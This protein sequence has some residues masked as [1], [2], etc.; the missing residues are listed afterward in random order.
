L[1]EEEATHEEPAFQCANCHNEVDED[2][3]HEVVLDEKLCDDCFHELYSTCEAC[4]D[5]VPSEEARHSSEYE[6]I[7]CED[8]YSRKH[9]SCEDC[10]ESIRADRAISYGSDY[11]CEGCYSDNYFTC[12]GCGAVYHIDHH[13]GDGYCNDCYQEENGDDSPS[14][15]FWDSPV[16]I[17]LSDS[18]DLIPSKRF[19]G[20]EL[21]A[22]TASSVTQKDTIF[23]A[24]PDGSIS[25]QEFVSPILQGDTGFEAIQILCKN[26]IETDKSCGFHLHLDAR[27]L[28]EQEILNIARGYKAIEKLLFCLVSES[29]QR[30]TFCQRISTPYETIKNL[31]DLETALYGYP[32]SCQKS[33]KYH[34]KRYEFLNLHSYF[35]RGSIEIR[36]HGGT[37]D[38][39]KIK[40]WIN[41][42]QALFDFFKNVSFNPIHEEEDTLLLSF[43]SK[44]KALLPYLRSRLQKFS[45]EETPDYLSLLDKIEAYSQ[46]LNLSLMKAEVA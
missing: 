26:D 27:D 3:T 45:Y 21:E 35:L 43:L 7:Q 16:K 12:E 34:N 5:V 24:V 44:N 2:D 41:L 10:G 25:G 23:S 17:V 42:H 37:F 6:E 4:G 22:C 32:G 36:L 31:E 30:S 38:A 15:T 29:R 1:P 8:C 13:N 19:Y 11:L 39:K 33:Q 9:E 46:N 40:G 28:N 20:V 14:P 18:F